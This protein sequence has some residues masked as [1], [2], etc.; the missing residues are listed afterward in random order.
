MFMHLKMLKYA[1]I[2]ALK[3]SGICTKNTEICAIQTSGFSS[4]CSVL[5]KNFTERIYRTAH[6]PIFF[7]AN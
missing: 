5:D 4:F 2:H 6:N 3:T 1:C 7:S